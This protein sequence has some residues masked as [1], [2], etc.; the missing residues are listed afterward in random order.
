[1]VSRDS[2]VLATNI[3]SRLLLT[4]ARRQSFSILLSGIGMYCGLNAVG[5][6]I[7]TEVEKDAN[8]D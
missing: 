8:R 4:W 6:S 5:A 7:K 1:M 2:S 3:R